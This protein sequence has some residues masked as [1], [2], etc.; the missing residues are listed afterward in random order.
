MPV[1]IEI[2]ARCKNADK[3][4]QILASLGAEHQG[5]DHQVDTY[6]KVENGRLKLR[7]GNIENNLIYYSRPNAAGPKRSDVILYPS[8]RDAGLKKILAE[9]QGILAVVDKHRDIFFIGNVKFHIDSVKGLGSFVEI[10]AIGSNEDAAKLEVQC[11]DYMRKL[12]I[13]EEDLVSVS[14]SDMILAKDT[15]A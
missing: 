5:T 10:E 1:N 4:R 8:S 2:K 14:Y 11:N 13:P 15:R 3:V 6:F 9:V 12:E 7:E